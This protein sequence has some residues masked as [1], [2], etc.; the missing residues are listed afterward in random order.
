MQDRLKIG[1]LVAVLVS[2]AGC[3][4]K[5]ASPGAGS[6]AGSAASATPSGSAGS[7]STAPAATREAL[8]IS[9]SGF[10]R[11][12]GL[13]YSD[14]LD[15]MEKAITVALAEHPEL[16]VSRGLM[17]FDGVIED[18]K[19]GGA[20]AGGIRYFSVKAGGKEV[21]QVLPQPEAGVL[22]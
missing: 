9:E 15:E 6:S 22:E 4:G 1:M 2:S 10:G 17:D 21:L 18:G 14:D 19:A 16:A 20:G 5:N 11:V 13:P 8:V 3:K 12:T 7:A